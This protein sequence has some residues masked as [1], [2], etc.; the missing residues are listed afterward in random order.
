MMH[1]HMIMADNSIPVAMQSNP[2][3]DTATK[4]DTIATPD[5]AY[6]IATTPEEN[7]T[8]TAN[9]GRVA[10]Q[11]NP[12]YGVMIKGIPMQSETGTN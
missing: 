9:V 6:D 4:E 8:A 3:Y 11:S 1:V 2:G 12:A 5:S 10:M 7:S